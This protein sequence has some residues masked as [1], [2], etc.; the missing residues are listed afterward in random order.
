M[1]GAATGEPAPGHAE[2]VA[3]ATAL[4]DA[5]LAE[6]AALDERDAGALS[7]LSEEKRRRVRTLE[8]ALEGALGTGANGTAPAAP[9][10]ALLRECAELNAHNAAK[11]AVRLAAV[12]SALVR[13]ARVSGADDAWGYAAD[14][15]PVRP[16]R[17]RRLG[18]G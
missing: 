6:R 5:L 13:L 4:R 10:A 8:G 1:S 17:G 18:E 12:R 16:V 7:G 3:A 14:G 15:A 2:A 9:V 11:V